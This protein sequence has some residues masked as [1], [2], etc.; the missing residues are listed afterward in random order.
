MTL[1]GLPELRALRELF[2][3]CDPAPRGAL[4]A[5]YAAANQAGRGERALELV[6]DSAD[7]PAAA[8][9]RGGRI[10][11]RPRVLTFMMPGRI[12]EVDLTSS[13]PGMIRARGLVVNRSGQTAPSGRLVLHHPDGEASGPLDRYGAFQVDDVPRGPVRV[14]F[15]PTGHDPVVADWLVC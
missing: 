9:V 3:T 14:A 7:E 8:R 4:V 1:E 10:A 11:P 12:V 5:A 6:G 15:H 2:Q 13:M